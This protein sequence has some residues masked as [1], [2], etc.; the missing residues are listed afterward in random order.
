M[1]HRHTL[2]VA[3]GA[4]EN[5]ERET[6]AA[7][8][9]VDR[10]SMCFK[11]PSWSRAHKGVSVLDTTFL[12]YCDRRVMLLNVQGIGRRTIQTQRL[13]SKIET[14]KLYKDRIREC[15]VHRARATR[16]PSNERI[17][18]R[19]LPL[20]IVVRVLGGLN[21]LLPPNLRGKTS[22]VTCE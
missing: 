16:L 8:S 14:E 22:L 1:R 17:L 12:L 5:G 2:H 7:P 6:F 18:R 3:F 9:G 21:G 11:G 10:D 20:G 13:Q 19:L 15:T 4:S